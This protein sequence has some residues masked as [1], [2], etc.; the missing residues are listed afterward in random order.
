[1][2]SAA[3]YELAISCLKGFFEGHTIYISIFFKEEKTELENSNNLLKDIEQ[4]GK[5]NKTGE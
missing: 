1:M 2:V 3:S 5:N 4:V